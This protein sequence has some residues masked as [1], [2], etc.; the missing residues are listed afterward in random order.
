MLTTIIRSEKMLYLLM[1]LVSFALGTALLALLRRL[2]PK[3][4]GRDFA[5]DGKLSAGKER[6]AGIL[7][8]AAFSVCALLFV[9]ITPKLVCYLLLVLASMLSGYLDDRARKPWNEY[10]KGAI[11]LAICA[12]AALSFV[13]FNPDKLT[14]NLIF[15]TISI[16]NWLFALGAVAFLWM[17]INAVNCSDGIDGFCGALSIHSLAFIAIIG[18]TLQ[19]DS[20]MTRLTVLMILSLLP[21]LWRN[22]QPSS[23]MMGDAG[24]R[25]IGL[26]LGLALLESGN[27][28]LSI[29]LCFVTLC[30]GLLG[31]AKVSLLRFLKIRILK[32]V[33][34]PLHDHFRK[35]KGWSNTQTIYRFLIVQT[36]ISLAALAL[37]R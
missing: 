13:R 31:I 29:P 16:P 28:L 12:S 25:A 1:L 27:V 17:M 33:R 7:F 9:P 19:L 26:F 21:Y 4:A 36:L 15:T 10:L 20:G 35:N 23:L 8:V 22:A 34:T 2:L 32:N 3:D 6:G 14:L 18:G 11:D 37:I 24:S 5:V 30:D